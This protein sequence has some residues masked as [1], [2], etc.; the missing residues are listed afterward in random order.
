M[1]ALTKM[2][3]PGA[4]SA[5][6]DDWQMNGGMMTDPVLIEVTRNGQ[7]ESRHCGMVAI[8]DANGGLVAGIGDFARPVFPRSAVKALQ[9]LPLVASGLAEKLGLGAPEIALACASHSGEPAHVTTA[10]GMLARVGRDENCLECGAHWPMNQDAMRAMA[11]RGETPHA[12]HNNC[13]GKHAGFVCLACAA[14][15]DPAGY[16]DPDHPVQQQV[17]AALVRMTDTPHEP[18]NR[19]IDGCSI[20]TYAVP[21]ESLA[22]AFA[23][24]GSG[25]RMPADY[26]QAA[27][28]I[29]NAV[30]QAPFMVA[31]TGRFDTRVM[32]RFCDRVFMKTGAEGVYCATIPERGLGIAV[33]C[34]DGTTRASEAI[35]ARI[36][37][38]LLARD[39]D[40]RAFLDDLAHAPLTNWNTIT[41][42]ALRPADALNDALARIS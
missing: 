16:I 33:K 7:V 3:G 42:G 1:V 12:G 2:S 10:Q 5:L 25:E 29:R 15:H 18:V 8:S 40:E 39:D 34:A 4:N 26:A 11:R 41:V 21:L 13:S 35:M 9:A 22:R 14:G 24:F 19:G 6:R 36:L 23:R 31:G 28:V 32:E 30:A 38:A 20:P 27:R 17:R 37:S